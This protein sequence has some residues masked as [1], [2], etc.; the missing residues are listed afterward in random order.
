MEQQQTPTEGDFAELERLIRELRE[1]VDGLR[2]A[3][4]DAEQLQARLGELG[5]L[6]GKAAA[7]LDAAAQ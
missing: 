1:Q 3:E 2:T 5:E 6:A 7:A 4:L